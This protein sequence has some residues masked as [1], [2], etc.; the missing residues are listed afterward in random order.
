MERF[1]LYDSLSSPPE[2]AAFDALGQCP[3]FP[4]SRSLHDEVPRRRTLPASAGC[5]AAL[6]CRLPGWSASLL[7]LES[8]EAGAVFEGSCALLQP[9]A[10][11]FAC[12]FSLPPRSH[13][14]AEPL[15]DAVVELRAR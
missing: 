2:C 14:R 7:R 4:G 11:G 9:G 1:S 6:V 3:S 5:V 12:R 15:S 8:T 10:E 13:E